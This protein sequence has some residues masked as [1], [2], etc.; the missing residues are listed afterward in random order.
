MS[1]FSNLLWLIRKKSI[2]NPENST[3]LTDIL[4]SHDKI[5]YVIDELV[6][7]TKNK[8]KKIQVLKDTTDKYIKNII[9][10]GLY[11]FSF[12]PLNDTS[13]NYLNKSHFIKDT[14]VYDVYIRYFEMNKYVIN[15]N[16]LGDLALNITHHTPC[17]DYY[18]Y[19]ITNG[20]MVHLLKLNSNDGKYYVDLSMMARYPVRPSFLPYGATA[21]FNKNLEIEKIIVAYNFNFVSNKIDFTK[22]SEYLI[23]DINWRFAHNIMMSSVQAYV[24]I[25]SHALET[26]FIRGETIPIILQK[27]KTKTIAQILHPFLFNTVSLNTSAAPILFGNKKYAHRLFAF[28]NDGLNEFI[29]DAINDESCSCSKFINNL[30]QSDHTFI[31]DDLIFYKNIFKEYLDNCFTYCPQI[32]IDDLITHFKNDTKNENISIEDI[33]SILINY[34]LNGT[35]LHEIV[36]TVFQYV[37]NPAVALI[38]VYKSNPFSLYNSIEAT[39]EA[40]QL[41]F[42]TTGIRPKIMDVIELTHYNKHN[43]IINAWTKLQTKLLSH[44]KLIKCN[45]LLPELLETSVSL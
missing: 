44:R 2:L 15:S 33:K 17:I 28:T 22:T 1:Y 9:N 26:H 32:E 41:V 25:I 35:I 14:Q 8:T 42:L 23:G 38:R 20:F 6:F 10:A 27:L 11:I 7:A 29:C 12:L 3:N 39:H 19:L 24:T 40:I 16:K 43:A 21:I 36:G 4:G 31:R 5:N 37:Y 18:K 34:M 45:M 13:T 30:I